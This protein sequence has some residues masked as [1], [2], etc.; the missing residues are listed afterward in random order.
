MQGMVSGVLLVAAFAAAAGACGLMALRLYRVSGTA[1]RGQAAAQ[2][3]PARRGRREAA[4]QDPSG[5]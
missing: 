3:E 5:A 1:G 4:E 2:G